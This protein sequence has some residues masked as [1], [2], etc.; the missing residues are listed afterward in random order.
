[1]YKKI[2][3]LLERWLVK[4]Y[5]KLEDVILELRHQLYFMDFEE[6]ESD[7]FIVTYLKSGTTWMQV[8]LH[9]LVTEGNMD[10]FMMFHLGQ[11]INLFWVNLLKK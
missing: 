7:I 1:M 10:L 3:T 11:K 6:R 9:N 5:K 8:I 4:I 2:I